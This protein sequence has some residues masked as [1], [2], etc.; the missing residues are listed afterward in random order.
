MN[1]FRG[2]GRVGGGCLFSIPFGQEVR[3]RGKGAINNQMSAKI[4]PASCLKAFFLKTQLL[5]QMT[6]VL[7]DNGNTW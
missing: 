4:A 2:G 3:G 6:H 1:S 5:G 7:L